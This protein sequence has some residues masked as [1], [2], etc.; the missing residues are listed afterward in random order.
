MDLHD[1]LT[2]L[3]L[4]LGNELSAARS[5]VEVVARNPELS[6]VERER[7]EHAAARLERAWNRLQEHFRAW[8]LRDSD[9]S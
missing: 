1:D 3:H 5:L 6:P 8:G 2:D 7:L 4:A 9:M